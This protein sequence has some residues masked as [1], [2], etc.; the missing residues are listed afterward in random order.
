MKTHE[1]KIGIYVLAKNA[2][3]AYAEECFDV[4]LN[5]GMAV[6]CD[7]LRRDGYTNIGYCS[8]VTV[9]DYDVVMFSVTSDCDWWTF[10]AER[11]MWKTGGY[12]V[13]VGGQGVLNPRP[14]LKWVDYFQLGR[15]ESYLVD[16]MDALRL[17]CEFE[18]ESVVCSNTFSMDKRYSIAQVENI[19]QHKITLPNG[20]E[21]AEDVIG[22]NHKCLFCGYTWHRKH[23]DTKEFAYSGLWNGGVDR[24]RAIID[25][26]NGVEVDMNKL[27]TTAI[28]GM[29][30]RI[31]FAV[32]KR[33]TREMLRRFFKTA[34]DAE[35][36]HQI[37]IYNII[38]YPT[39][40]REDWLEFL[41][42]MRYVDLSYA[43]KSEHQTSWLLHST[44]FRAMPATPLACESMAYKNYR[45]EVARILGGG[46]YKGNIFYQ[47]NKMWG[48]E[49]MATESLSTVIKSAIIWR[50]VE[51]DARAIELICRNLKK[52]E[53][54][55]SQVKQKTLEAHFDVERLFSRYNP[56][57]LPTRNI[58]TYCSVEKM[59]G[60][61][62]FSIE[63]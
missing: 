19:Y 32:N 41:D 9:Q 23:S 12:K 18:N 62:K 42:D 5:A 60:Q 15:C 43:G 40:T 25:M 52:F 61:N 33:I 1:L 27:R 36:P 8:S 38:G 44:P 39:E 21:Y 47:G 24:E 35:H 53:A 54:A 10:I 45:G 29:S 51:S 2:K 11:V 50:G 16:F 4:R 49:S 58:R 28:D 7:I 56:N 57:D 30:E 59:W 31:R 14:F 63:G 17:G 55:N 20:E 3:Q 46:K 26:D 6:V 34:S 37:K 48:V 13:V 22:C